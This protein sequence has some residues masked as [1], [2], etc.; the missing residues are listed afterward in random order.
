VKSKVVETQI[1]KSATERGRV[2]HMQNELPQG[3]YSIES[4]LDNY[5]T[6]NIGNVA[7][8]N[9][10]LTKLVIKLKKIV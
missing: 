2:V 3:N 6:N 4:T 8:E 5:N 1:I 7:V 9:G 10:K